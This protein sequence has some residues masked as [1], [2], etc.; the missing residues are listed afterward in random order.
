M[1]FVLVM[2]RMLDARYRN[3]VKV[4]QRFAKFGDDDYDEVYALACDV[5]RFANWEYMKVDLVR[6]Y[7]SQKMRI[8]RHYRKKLLDFYIE[9]DCY[10]DDAFLYRFQ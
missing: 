9:F 7:F 2:W 10:A 1:K 6:D 4:L 3:G 8:D 5:K